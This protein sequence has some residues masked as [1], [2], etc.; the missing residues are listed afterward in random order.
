MK[1]LFLLLGLGWLGVY[2]QMKDYHIFPEGYRADERAKLKVLDVKEVSFADM[3][4]LSFSGISALAYGEDEGLYALSDRGALFRLELLIRDK[5]IKRLVLK[6]AYALRDRDGNI[7]IRKMRD[8]EGMLLHEDGLII[9]FEQ[10]PKLSLYTREGKEVSAFPLPEVL[11]DTSNYQGKNKSLEAVTLHKNYGLITAPEAPLKHENQAFHT[12]Y[13]PSRR[14]KFP[15]HG[16]ITSLEVLDDQNILVLEREF[17]ILHGQKITLSKLYIDS[18]SGLL[19][20]VEV[21]ASW[22]SREGWN[23]DN[24]EGLTRIDE[25]QFLMIS[26][27]NA[28]PF[29]RTLL[30]LFELSD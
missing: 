14:W 4:G 30:V 11:R 1:T 29:Q 22:E 3:K 28:N 24:F 5:K 25:H 2:A 15:L 7:P 9:S 16:N 26:D 20:P 18:C 23:I 21:L 13:S 8:S 17:S 6:E 10:K 19:C 27:D 12:L